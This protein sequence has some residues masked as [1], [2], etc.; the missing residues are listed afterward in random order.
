[1]ILAFVMAL[2]HDAAVLFFG[3]GAIHIGNLGGSIGYAVFMSFAIIVGNFHGFRTGEWKG[4]SPKSIKLIMVGIA[5]LV[6]GV[7]ILG[8]GKWMAPPPVVTP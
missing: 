6:I 5:I 1:M 3:L 4:A 8:T 2:L 7:A